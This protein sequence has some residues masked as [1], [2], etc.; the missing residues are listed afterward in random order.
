VHQIDFFFS[1]AK[2]RSVLTNLQHETQPKFQPIHTKSKYFQFRES[3]ESSNQLT[4]QQNQT[5]TQKLAKNVH[6]IANKKS[7]IWSQIEFKDR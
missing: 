1:A 3:N 4:P 2:R 5:D 6:T 7:L